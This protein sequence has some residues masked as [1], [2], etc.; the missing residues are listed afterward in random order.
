MIQTKE[1]FKI[2]PTVYLVLRKDDKIL[3]AR[4]CNTGFHD[5]D[6][7]F[8]AGHVELGETMINA[9]LREAKEEIGIILK[10]TDLRLINVMHRKEPNEER[11]NLF[12]TTNNWEGEPMIMEPDK[13]DDIKWFNVDSIPENTIPYIKKVLECMQANIFYSEFGW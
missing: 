12:F 3:L 13:C 2:I 11:I 9:M 4:R 8:P 6:Y 10:P 1:R 5:G 7:S